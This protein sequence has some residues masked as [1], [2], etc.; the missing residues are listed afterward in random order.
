MINV[1]WFF[2][3]GI[4]IFFFF[5]KSVSKILIFFLF[6]VC[7]IGLY[8][9]LN[10][11]NRWLFNVY[12]IIIIGGLMISFFYIVRLSHNTIFSKLRFFLVIISLFNFFNFKKNIELFFYS[13]HEILNLNF[14]FIKFVFFYFLFLIF[15]LIFIIL[16]LYFVE[17]KLKNFRGRIKDL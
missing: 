11:K 2:I 16:I 13:S 12:I 4:V 1:T 15:V 7:I 8:I 9:L 10:L 3:I 14:F 5:E 17:L 6:T